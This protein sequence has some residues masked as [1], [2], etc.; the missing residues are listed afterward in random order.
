[1]WELFTCSRPYADV[2]EDQIAQRVTLKGLRPL[3]PPD[4]PRAYRWGAGEGSTSTASRYP[5][6]LLACVPCAAQPPGA[7]AGANGR[8]QLLHG[9]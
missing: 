5:Y 2:P 6:S 1:M 3:F 7:K 4:T 9:H 8:K